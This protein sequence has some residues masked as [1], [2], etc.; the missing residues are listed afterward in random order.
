[1]I[2][3]HLEEKGLERDVIS[4]IIHVNEVVNV[5]DEKD[6][7]LYLVAE[8]G[9]DYRIGKIVLRNIQNYLIDERENKNI[10]YSVK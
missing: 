9:Y 3:W 7:I 1:M 4:L 5:V 10:K 2:T 6:I 8:L